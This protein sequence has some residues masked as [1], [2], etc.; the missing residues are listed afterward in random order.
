MSIGR[1]RGTKA[2]LCKEDEDRVTS[3][4]FMVAKKGF[5]R[6]RRASDPFHPGTVR[7]THLPATA[8]C[9]PGALAM[10]W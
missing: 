4:K 9:K 2:H 6:K 8:P 10:R 7:E 3:D 1:V 5:Y